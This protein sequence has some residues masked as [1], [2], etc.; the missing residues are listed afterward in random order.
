MTK[1][2]KESKASAYKKVTYPSICLLINGIIN[3]MFNLMII[4]SSIASLKETMN[5]RI[6]DEAERLGY[7][8]AAIVIP[9]V[10][11]INIMIAP[12]IIYGAVQMMNLK[13]YKLSKIASVLTIIPLTS[14]CCILGIPVGI[15]G[16]VTLRKAEVKSSF[17]EK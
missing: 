16:L 9:V 10:A 14:S 1:E 5:T 4:I 2:D 12:I 6:A 15:W 11:I 3:G 7:F 17:D 8:A 13:K